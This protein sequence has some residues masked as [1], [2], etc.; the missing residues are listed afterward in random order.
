VLPIGLAGHFPETVFGKLSGSPWSQFDKLLQTNR[1][2]SKPIQRSVTN[3]HDQ[4]FG[5]FCQLSSIKLA[6]FLK[7]MLWSCQHS[8]YLSHDRQFF[9][10]FFRQ[11]Y[12]KNHNIGPRGISWRHPLKQNIVYIRVSSTV[13]DLRTHFK[14]W[15][16]NNFEV[17][18]A[19]W[20]DHHNSK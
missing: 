3:V 14:L 12:F 20:K 17:M 2:N 10:D 7:P 5:R 16:S 15:H 19:W 13:Y 4:N 6:F 1:R 18:A 11:K 9:S 8:S